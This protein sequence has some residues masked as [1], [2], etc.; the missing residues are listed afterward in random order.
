MNW[1]MFRYAQSQLSVSGEVSARR[2]DCRGARADRDT[3]M[4]QS[5]FDGDCVCGK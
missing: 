4:H 1:P 5:L 3:Q 2:C